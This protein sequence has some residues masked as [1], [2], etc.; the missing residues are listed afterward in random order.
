MEQRQRIGKT[1]EELANLCGVTRWTIGN[2]ERGERP[3][4][5][6]LVRE[7]TKLGFDIQYI[8]SGVRSDNLDKVAEEAGSYERKPQGVGVLSK[9]EEAL[10]K[11]YRQLDPG[12]RTHA[13]AV[14]DALASA[15]V[16]KND[17]TG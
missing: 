14:V 1:Q 4:G 8:F 9:E 2:I 10:V 15:A 7:L 13:Q 6:E 11:K 3:P 16:V 12:K 17:K 5:G